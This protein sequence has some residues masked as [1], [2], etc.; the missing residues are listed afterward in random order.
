MKSESP[1]EAMMRQIAIL[2]DARDAIQKV[3]DDATGSVD[4]DN[5]TWRDVSRLAYIVDQVKRAE[6]A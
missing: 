3:I 5:A 6:L 4:P 1:T 2:T